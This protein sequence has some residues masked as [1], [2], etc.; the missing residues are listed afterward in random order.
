[1]ILRRV[2]AVMTSFICAVSAFASETATAQASPPAA[3]AIPA[4]YEAAIAKARPM[5]GKPGS[6][7]QAMEQLGELSVRA[8]N[9]LELALA[10]GDARTAAELDRLIREKLGDTRWRVEQDAVA[11][12]ADALLAIG[13]FSARNLLAARNMEKACEAFVKAAEREHVAGTYQAALCRL[14]TDPERAAAWMQRAAEAGHPA[15]REAVGR[16][17]LERKPEPQFECA[18][19]YVSEAAQAGRPSAQSL[20]GWMYANGAGVPKDASRASRLYLEAA[21]KQDVAAQNNLGELY[22][23]GLGVAKNERLAAGWYLQAAQAGFAPAQ[24]NLGRL[25]ALGAEV[26]RNPAQAR[27]WLEKAKAQGIDRA[28][29]VLRWLALQGW[30]GSR[31]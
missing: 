18:V 5:V 20:L 28:D 14:K 3:R 13:I 30:D 1:M 4:D 11:G 23:K 8:A 10:L 31:R 9:D 27:L 22:E 29:E 6:H 12:D 2:A 15:A 24:F 26:D 7:D 19:R 25:Y 21:R 17:C 16:A